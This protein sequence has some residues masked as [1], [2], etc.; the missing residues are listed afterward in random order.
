MREWRKSHP[1]FGDARKRSNARSYLHMYI[2]RGKIEKKPCL[3][4]GNTKSEAHHEDYS[5]PLDVKWFCR[6]H[7][8]KY[9][10]KMA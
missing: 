8:L 3:V 7:H 5:K 9:H 6:F 10:G 2:K 1:L 4:C